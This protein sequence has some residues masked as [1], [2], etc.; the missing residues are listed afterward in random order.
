MAYMCNSNE[1]DGQPICDDTC[2]GCRHFYGAYENT[3]CCNY[4]FDTGR[5]RPCPAGAG[6]TVFKP[7][8]KRKGYKSFT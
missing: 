8:P 6:C 7:P 1:S 5:R 2:I 4:Y 3:R